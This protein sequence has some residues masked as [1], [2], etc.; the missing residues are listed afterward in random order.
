[1]DSEEDIDIKIPR[2]LIKGSPSVFTKPKKYI[3]SNP[4]EGSN[5]HHA[6]RQLVPRTK[7]SKFLKNEKE[8]KK[9]K[10]ICVV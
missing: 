10:D 9:Q 1:M 3:Y 5:I 7:K 8:N 4:L 2:D 6:L